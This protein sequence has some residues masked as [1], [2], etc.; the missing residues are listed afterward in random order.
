MRSV[1]SSYYFRILIYIAVIVII[2]LVTIAC[3]MGAKI[4]TSLVDTTMQVEKL[5]LNQSI[6]VAEEKLKSIQSSSLQFSSSPDVRNAMRVK[7]LQDD[8]QLFNQLRNSSLALMQLPSSGIRINGIQVLGNDNSWIYD[9]EF[10]YQANPD[11]ENFVPINSQQDGWHLDGQYVKNN[12]FEI[13]R[14]GTVLVWTKQ[15]LNIGSVSVRTNYEDFCEN[16]DLYKPFS[17]FHILDKDFGIIYGDQIRDEDASPEPLPFL[18]N[19]SGENGE[20]KYKK[21]GTSYSCIYAQ[22]KELGWYYILSREETLSLSEFWGGMTVTVIAS[23][24]IVLIA[25]FFVSR[26][27]RKLYRPISDLYQ[28]LTIAQGRQSV[29]DKK[30]LNELQE[31][32][33]SI[34]QMIG[35]NQDL[36]LQISDQRNRMRELLLYQLFTGHLQNKKHLDQLAAYEI[37]LP[38]KYMS[39]I[40]VLPS[41]TPGNSESVN[42]PVS[43]VLFLGIAEIIRRTSPDNSLVAPIMIKDMIFFLLGGEQANFDEF[44]EA[45]AYE[46]YNGIVST[47]HLEPQIAVSNSFEN[48]NEIS[49]AYERIKQILYFQGQ[50]NKGVFLQKSVVKHIR[51][52]NKNS[53][54]ILECMKSGKD[55]NMLAYLDVFLDDVFFHTEDTYYQQLYMMWLIGDILRL[56][57]DYSGAIVNQS[58]K[59]SPN[60][61]DPVQILFAVDSLSDKKD[62]LLSNV[63]QPVNEILHTK[64]AN[65]VFIVK[66]MLSFIKDNAGEAD[67]IDACAE[68]LN[69]N[70]SYLRKVFRDTM[71]ISYSHYIS[72]TLLE[73]ACKL[74]E[75]TDTSINDIALMLGYS[76]SQ[77]FIRYFKKEYG[78]TPGQYRNLPK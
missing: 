41:R 35:D 71:G 18:S 49:S 21:N 65:K 48:I 2:P 61:Q 7:N 3:V 40:G 60:F 76:N 58:T 67:D 51:Y 72:R 20:F 1:K 77:N 14:N 25:I 69:Y 57:P 37:E 8:F 78:M 36:R 17:D 70:A 22:S 75:T 42:E 32:E 62:W 47:L 68:F 46:I 19:I 4:Y 34:S 66:R 26:L 33:N 38:G 31:I 73:N 11:A 13:E 23:L 52:P 5:A 45:T 29:S 64:D 9:T 55:E 63:I 27:S 6:S 56:V 50:Q 43:E 10:G 16:F 24:M 15:Y 30:K 59:S 54:M 44:T 12:L 39:L 53:E 28:S 74:L